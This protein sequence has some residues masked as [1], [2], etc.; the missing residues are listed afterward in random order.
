MFVKSKDINTID[1][2]SNKKFGRFFDIEQ[3]PNS[4][5]LHE[6]VRW[7]DGGTELSPD[8]QRDHA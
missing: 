7:I 3:I 6:F 4:R 2:H 5:G 1:E 8:F